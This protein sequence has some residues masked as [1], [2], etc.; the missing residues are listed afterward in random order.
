MLILIP[1]SLIISAVCLVVIFF[2][3]GKNTNPGII[4]PLALSGNQN[5]SFLNS[6]ENKLRDF[7]EREKI[8]FKDFAY[9]DNTHYKI[10]LD[11]NKEILISAGGDMREELSSLQ[12]ILSRLTMEGREFARLDLRYEKPIIVFK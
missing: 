10:I 3:I 4:S 8:T 2:L 7:L 6:G 9:I 1:V 12:Y 5:A 11:D